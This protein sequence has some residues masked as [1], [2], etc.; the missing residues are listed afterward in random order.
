MDTTPNGSKDGGAAWALGAPCDAHDMPYCA[1]CAPSN[2][3]GEGTWDETQR[4]GRRD[5]QRS[6]TPA[7]SSLYVGPDEKQT[8]PT[9]ADQRKK[10]KKAPKRSASSSPGMVVG[11]PGLV[12]G[13]K[14]RASLPKPRTK[15]RPSRKKKD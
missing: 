1:D 13:T 15:A 12:D 10:L 4:K 8:A 3:R 6:A 5:A 9:P 7:G 11:R 14:P 2:Y